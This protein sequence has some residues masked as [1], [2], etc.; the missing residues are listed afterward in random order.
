MI[1]RPG[2][3]ENSRNR[4]SHM[5]QTERERD[6]VVGAK[7]HVIEAPMSPQQLPRKDYVDAPIKKV[8]A[9]KSGLDE[10][11]FEQRRNPEECAEAKA[12]SDRRSTGHSGPKRRT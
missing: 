3:D 2:T 4:E 12:A 6:P 5:D 9:H 1:Q 7:Y 8:C 10:I 11:L